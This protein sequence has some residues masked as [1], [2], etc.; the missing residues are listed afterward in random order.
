MYVRVLI[1]SLNCHKYVRRLIDYIGL[2]HVC[3]WID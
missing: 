3:K 1:D 2:S